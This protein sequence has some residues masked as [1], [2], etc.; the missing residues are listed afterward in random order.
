MSPTFGRDARGLGEPKLILAT[1]LSSPLAS[2]GVVNTSSDLVSFRSTLG[3]SNVFGLGVEVRGATGIKGTA[4]AIVA[5][6]VDILLCVELRFV[7]GE[8]CLEVWTG[9]AWVS[10]NPGGIFGVDERRPELCRL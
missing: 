3:V 2:A 8:A 1:S 7:T 5:D 9:C 6:V 10:S 4:G